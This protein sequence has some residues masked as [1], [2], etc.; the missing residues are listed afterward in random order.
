MIV[1]ILVMGIAMSILFP[2]FL[3]TANFIAIMRGFSMEALVVV[4]MSTLLIAGP[5][6][7]RSALSWPCPGSSPPG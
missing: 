6:T 7:C 4:G 5:L 1:L 2:Y 3:N